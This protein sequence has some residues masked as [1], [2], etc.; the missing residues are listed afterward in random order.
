[1]SEFQKLRNRAKELGIKAAGT[2]VNAAFLRKAIAAKEYD[3]EVDIEAR[4]KRQSTSSPKATRREVAHNVVTKELDTIYC[5]Y[6]V[7]S[8]RHLFFDEDQIEKL[9][10]RIDEHF[11]VLHGQD[12][13]ELVFYDSYNYK[14]WVD[15]KY[16]EIEEMFS[17]VDRNPM[18][19]SICIKTIYPLEVY[20]IV[21]EIAA[22]GA[23]DRPTKISTIESKKGDQ[24]IGF[25]RYEFDTYV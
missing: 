10:S 8:S 1:M 6:V 12:A 19:G 23:F 16:K 25:V 14:G 15:P 7:F 22:I 5:D 20:T 21:A 17:Y 11:D 2:G 13:T 3:M 18:L 9:K 24:T 4:K